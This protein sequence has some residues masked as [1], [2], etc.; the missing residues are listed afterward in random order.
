M[1][2]LTDLLEIHEIEQLKYRYLRGVDL[3]DWDTLEDCFIEDAT[4]SYGGGVMSYSGRSAIMDFLRASLGATSMLTSHK[5]HHPEIRLIP[6]D[7]A[8]G[9]WGLDDYVIDQR[10]GV[11]IRGAAYYQDSYVKVA[12]GWRISHTGYKRV[13]EEIQP[14]SEQTGLSLTAEWWATDGRSKLI[15]GK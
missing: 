3:K 5:C 14:R 1:M 4:A 11:T 9:M 10:F 6:P 2:E 7:R 15:G 13:F 12:D 8:E